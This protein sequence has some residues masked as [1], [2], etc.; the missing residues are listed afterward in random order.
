MKLGTDIIALE[1]GNDELLLLNGLQRRPLYV[2]EGREYVKK[3]LKTADALGSRRKIL[4]AY[5]N[6]SNLLEV[7]L[8]FG[9]LTLGEPFR[10]D[11]QDVAR[12][13][14]ECKKQAIS[15]YLLLSQSCNLGCVYC[16]AGRETYQ[17]GRRLRMTAPVAFR[18]IDRFL[19]ELVD[20]GRLEV[21]F[22]GGEPLLNWPLAKQFI[23]H[24]EQ[25]LDELSHSKQRHY[26]FTSNLSFL[27]TELIEWAKR[28]DISFLCDVDGPAAIHDRSRPFKAG[29]GSFQA[30]ERSIARLREAGLRV[31]LRATVT[32]MNHDCLL[33]VAR[34]HK[35]LG[36]TS[37]A[38]VPVMPVN[39]DEDILP[40]AMLPGLEK[41]LAGLKEVY[42][43]TIWDAENLYPFNQYSW[44]FD[45]GSTSAVGCGAPY[46]NTP[47]VCADGKVYPCI[48]LV[49]LKRYYLGNILDESYPDRSVL[50]DIFNRV[51][52]A[53]VDECRNCAWRHLCCGG[54]PLGRLTV[55]DNPL[56]SDTV[57]EYCRRMQ[58]DYTKAILEMVLWKKATEAASDQQKQA[59]RSVVC[60]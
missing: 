51:S 33:E 34:T 25:R 56:A 4:K 45:P 22:F 9:I 28:Y 60:I 3:F 31:D 8:H 17:T 44:R 58:C 41:M 30:I 49:G 55:P 18:T 12:C 16:L 14:G 59:E 37:S 10:S 52:V 38:F 26:H 43:S 54:C 42:A 23:E 46:G 35:E 40:E 32:S 5:P 36:G 53:N 13:S 19:E 50:A 47:V 24:C 11:H 2:K 29:R 39:S 20:G 7:L 15:L 1:R 6:D 57:K 27:P 48:Y 21:I